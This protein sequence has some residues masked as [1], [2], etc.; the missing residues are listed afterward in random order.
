[1]RRL[2]RLPISSVETRYLAKKQQEILNGADVVTT[3]KSARRT[4][5]MK[6]VAVTLGRVTGVRQ[7]CMY[8]EDSRA[9]DIDH[10]RPKATYPALVFVW[11]NFLWVCTGC[12]REKS[13]A[14]PITAAGLP[15]L[16]NPLDEDPWHY[17][18]FDKDTDLIVARV[19]P[20]TG[21]PDPKAT[22]TLKDVPPL[23]HEAIIEGR[24]RTRRNLMRAVRAFLLAADDLEAEPEL[25]RSL[26]DNDAYGLLAWFVLHDP[27]NTEPFATLKQKYPTLWEQIRFKIVKV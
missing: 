27:G 6:S 3:W 19:D 11:E 4:N 22:A 8:C 21:M 14:F 1:M 25:L 12:N 17:L 24:G 23:S 7:R 16:I 2:I 5:P 26:S 13:S 10:F 15:L 9:T 20:N 18:F